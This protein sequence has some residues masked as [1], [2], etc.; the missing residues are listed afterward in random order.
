MVLTPIRSERSSEVGDFTIDLLNEAASQALGLEKFS[1][2]GRGLRQVL[3]VDLVHALCS[4]C[5]E[6]SDTGRP[7]DRAVA[8]PDPLTD[9]SGTSTIAVRVTALDSTY[10]CTW[11]PGWS[12]GCGD[13]RTPV[14]MPGSSVTDRLE[15]AN[16]ADAL[17]EAGVGVY[18]FDL[19]TGRLIGSVGLRQLI[20]PRPDEPTADGAGLVSLLETVLSRSE[21]W[22]A[23]VRH[24]TPMDL[25]I[26]L[27]P[28]GSG[29]KLRCVGRVR[30]GP[31]GYPTVVR[32]AIWASA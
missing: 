1:L 6:A 21:E 18:S 29:R 32:G 31:D 3:P 27:G 11:L 26:G 4:L 19:T 17:A 23:L 9:L 16:A 2:T 8:A 20:D 12:V 14:T 7:V 22:Q 13:G 28:H 30:R 24:G 15:L 10:L 25:R 5:A